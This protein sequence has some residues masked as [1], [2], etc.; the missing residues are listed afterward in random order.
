VVKLA[1]HDRVQLIRVPGH[2]RTDGIE[3]AD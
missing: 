2:M 1:E 3:T